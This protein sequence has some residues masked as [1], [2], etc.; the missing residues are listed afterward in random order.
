MICKWCG[1][2]T[3]PSA[4]KC[5][6]CRR[7]LPPL[8]DC[9]GFYN[10]MPS[11]VQIRPEQKITETFEPGQRPAQ[12]NLPMQPGQPQR[13]NPAQPNSPAPGSHPAGQPAPVGVRSKEGGKKS[14]A[15]L[16]AAMAVAGVLLLALIAV[17]V[18]F[19]RTNT[20]LHEAEQKIDRLE[21]RLT[22][23]TEPAPEEP[24]QTAST[25]AE[26][27]ESD[28]S[29]STETQTE[30]Q[31][32][33]ETKS[34]GAT[35]PSKEDGEAKP[36]KPL[37]T[38]RSVFSQM[39]EP[40]PEKVTLFID[41]REK[42]W[43]ITAD[44]EDD[45]DCFAVEADHK[46]PENGKMDGY[47]AVRFTVRLN[48]EDGQD[49]AEIARVWLGYRREGSELVFKTL[50]EI[51]DGL[52]GTFLGKWKDTEDSL[53]YRTAHSKWK[54]LSKNQSGL[55]RVDSASSDLSLQLT[56]T[57]T[58]TEGKSFVI[59]ITDITLDDFSGESR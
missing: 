56:C 54:D 48:A 27:G 51:P 2:N 59:R 43:N 46:L 14:A 31:T 9:G 55:F 1:E 39:G 33:T 3:D 36:T 58:N 13:Q 17:L 7:P 37:V 35:E 6:H 53:A 45:S 34:S 12:Q 21:Q 24:E 47:Q 20:A 16:I 50:M 29:A 25:Q 11:A 52:D 26:S 40:E 57:R 22:E 38:D 41:R 49:A 8:S 19:L 23:E 42:D 18:L 44:R 4:A 5:T 15:P 30:P 32:T 28:A 10:I